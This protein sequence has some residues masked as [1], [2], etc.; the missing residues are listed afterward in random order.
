MR[1]IGLLN[2]LKFYILFT[3]II[4]A[5]NYNKGKKSDV[6]LFYIF[7]LS[8]T[9]EL[10]SLI[11]RY[12][13]IPLFLSGTIYVVT[14]NLL[15]LL[16]LYQIS[17]LKRAIIGGIILFILFAIYNFFFIE[18][19]YLFN[20][21]SFVFGSMLYVILF[22]FD[23]FYELKKENLSYFLSN[24]YILLFSPVMFF[25]GFSLLFGFKNNEI[26]KIKCFNNLNLYECIS[27]FSNIIYY[28]LINIY[29]YRSKT[30]KHVT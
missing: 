1:I 17:V 23:S 7:L 24:N 29:I 10:L 25:I 28:T 21:N 27:Y 2:P 13:T 30:H 3:F 11:F 9:N 20:S 22:I 19:L 4:V 12:F 26:D 16:I 18:G 15:W 8:F 14:N 5:V 6:I